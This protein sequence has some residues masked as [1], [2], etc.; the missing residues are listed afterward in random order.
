V[1]FHVNVTG[2]G[3]PPRSSV[4]GGVSSIMYGFWEVFPR[5]GGDGDVAVWAQ[6][7]TEPRR[8]FTGD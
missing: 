3:P 6:A 7:C 1:E 5:D 4:D 8:N 2:S